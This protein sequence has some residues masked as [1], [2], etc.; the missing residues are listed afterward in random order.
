M[1]FANSKAISG[2]F[3]EK[4]LKLSRLAIV[5][6]GYWHGFDRGF[7]SCG[8]VLI[9]GARC[10]VLGRVNMDIIV[11]DVSNVQNVKIND[12]V[13]ILGSSGKEKITAEDMAMKIDTTNYEIVTRINPLI[14]R[15]YV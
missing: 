4:T 11:V 3:A 15:F 12:E 6:I 10:K 13:V 2:V 8:E 5:P 9:K 1:S 7:S 14:K